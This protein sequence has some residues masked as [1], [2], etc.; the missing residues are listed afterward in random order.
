MNTQE[1]SDALRMELRRIAPDIDPQAID[2][3]ASLREEYDIDSMDFL[4]LV[5]ALGKRFQ[6]SMPEADYPRLSTFAGVVAYLDERTGK[7]T[8]GR[9]EGVSVAI[10]LSRWLKPGRSEDQASAPN[11]PR[12]IS[13][14]LSPARM[15]NNASR[16]WARANSGPFF[17]PS[18]INAVANASASMQVCARTVTEAMGLRTGPALPGSIVCETV[19]PPI[20]AQCR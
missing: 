14:R 17:S 7:Q 10:V 2:P 8:W 9:V 15:T 1:I 12:P 6:L 19:S 5:T 13:E 11:F 18:T 3:N 16:R 4:N 20:S